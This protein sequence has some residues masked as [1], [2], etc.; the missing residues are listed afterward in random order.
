MNKA[1]SE[2][3]ALGAALFL[4]GK[5]VKNALGFLSRGTFSR[6]GKAEKEGAKMRLVDS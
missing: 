1:A 3:K 2:V 4:F 5:E 6:R